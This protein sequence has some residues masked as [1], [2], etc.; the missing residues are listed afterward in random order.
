VKAI[1]TPIWRGALVTAAAAIFFPK[2]EAIK[3]DDAPLWEL[4]FFFVPGDVEG[5]ILVPLVVLLTVAILRSSVGGLGATAARA[6]GR[7]GSA[8]WPASWALSACSR[9][10]S[11]PRSSSAGSR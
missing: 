11:A 10:F 7:Q 8:L 5:V 4:L 6:I 1:P 3:N 9:S 2:I